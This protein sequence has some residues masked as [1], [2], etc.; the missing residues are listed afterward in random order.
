[1]SFL[2]LQQNNCLHYNTNMYYNVT[3]YEELSRDIYLAG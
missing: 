1:M 3:D 2:L